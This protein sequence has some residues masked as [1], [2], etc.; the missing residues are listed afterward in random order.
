MAQVHDHNA[1][2]IDISAINTYSERHGCVIVLIRNTQTA[3]RRVRLASNRGRPSCGPIS[4]HTDGR[5]P[6]SG[7]TV[8]VVIG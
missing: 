1:W 4:N 7:V 2:N 6:N 3:R 5:D 8:A